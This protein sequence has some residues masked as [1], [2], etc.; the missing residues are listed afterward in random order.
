[1]RE[2]KRKKEGKQYNPIVRFFSKYGLTIG[3]FALIIIIILFMILK[4]VIS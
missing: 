3:A 2:E 1:M 4:F